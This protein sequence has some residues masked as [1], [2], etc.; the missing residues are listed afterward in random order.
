MAQEKDEVADAIIQHKLDEEI[1]KKRQWFR[2]K[3][4]SYQSLT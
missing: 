1:S 2:A 3:E 4:L